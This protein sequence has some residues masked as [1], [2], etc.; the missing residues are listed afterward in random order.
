[1]AVTSEIGKFPA[2]EGRVGSVEVAEWCLTKRRNDGS[3]KRSSCLL[4]LLRAHTVFPGKER[5][6][7]IGE[8]D[9]GRRL[10]AL[11]AAVCVSQLPAEC[12]RQ[13]AILLFC[14]MVLRVLGR[15]KV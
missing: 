1:M 2:V 13:P 11:R 8:W 10:C 12:L 15:R 6:T 7:V 14:C 4:L 3:D 5:P 9:Q